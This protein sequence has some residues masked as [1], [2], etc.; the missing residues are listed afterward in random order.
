MNVRSLLTLL[1]MWIA[2]VAY[3]QG[4]AG[5]GLSAEG[6]AAVDPNRPITFPQDHKAH[7]DYRIE[8]WYLTANLNDAAGNPL[9]AQWTVFR[10]TSRPADGQ[11]NAWEDGQIWLGHAAVTLPDQHYHI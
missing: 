1:F 4:F 9:G 10:N 8:W 6:Y 7:T 11:S 3:A 5:L 2:P